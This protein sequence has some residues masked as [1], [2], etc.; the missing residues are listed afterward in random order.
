VLMVTASIIGILTLV[1]LI[2]PYSLL[3]FTFI[4]GLSAAFL[5][6]AMQATVPDL[7]SRNELPS[8]LTLNGLGSSAA[9]A[10]G[11]AIAGLILAA[12][13]VGWMF[14]LNV[15]AFIGLCLVVFFWHNEHWVA[16]KKQLSF[17]GAFMEGI[18]YAKS[19]QHF[20]N[21]LIKSSTSFISISIL[22]ALLP[23]IVIENLRGGPGVLG[24]LL[25]FFGVGS[26]ICSLLLARLYK[27]FSRHTVINLAILAHSAAVILIASTE[28]L[29]IA[30][31]AMFTCGVAWTAVMT[32]IN[33][34]AQ[35][36]LPASIRARG[37]SISMMAMMGALFFGS[38]LWGQTAEFISL[39]QTYLI[40]GVFGLAV[41][42]L[43]IKF[44]VEEHTAVDKQG[45]ARARDKSTVITEGNI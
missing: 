31:L 16:S 10:I 26:V 8:A 36:L 27:Q 22:L 39:S 32:S 24:L 9:R 42:I 5:S 15:F 41:P 13:G 3:I 12:T 11:P 44:R 25:S 45:S 37:L 21:L 1:N 19:N 29:Y 23:L 7:I 18:Y 17:T 30:S 38:I 20:K 6:P 2:T 43:T 34:V 33:I 14:I 35:L 4:F 28:N 40:A